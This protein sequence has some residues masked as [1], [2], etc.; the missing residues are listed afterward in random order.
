MAV[1]MRW[2]T[3]NTRFRFNDTLDHLSG[4]RSFE[5]RFSNVA[6]EERTRY[7]FG[8]DANRRLR[9]SLIDKTHSLS[10]V[11]LWLAFGRRLFASRSFRF[12]FDLALC[13]CTCLFSCS[14]AGERISAARGFR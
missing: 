13:V 11:Q 8:G 3:K 1:S 4:F 10:V 7:L 12:A 6:I 5:R 2:R 9:V 14:V